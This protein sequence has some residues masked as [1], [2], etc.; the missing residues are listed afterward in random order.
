[1]LRGEGRPS[2]VSCRSPHPAPSDWYRETFR[3]K[4]VFSGEQNEKDWFENDHKGFRM[5]FGV[6]GKGTGFRGDCLVVDDPLSAKKQHSEPALTG[7]VQSVFATLLAEMLFPPAQF[8]QEPSP[9]KPP[10]TRDGVGRY[11]QHLGRLFDAQTTEKAQF[12]YLGFTPINFSKSI[13]G[14]V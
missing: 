12:D 2:A 8:G 13:Q 4:W 9:R 5:A 10:V 6:G 1:M 3:P 7:V 11:L 14:V